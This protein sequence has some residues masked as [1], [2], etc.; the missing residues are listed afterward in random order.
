M[1]RLIIALMCALTL[2]VGTTVNVMAAESPSGKPDTTPSTGTEDKAPKTGEGN[3]LIYALAT[4][5]VLGGTAVV[6]KKK[7]AESK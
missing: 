1:K 3:M 4:A 6:S 2:M 5:A 7:L